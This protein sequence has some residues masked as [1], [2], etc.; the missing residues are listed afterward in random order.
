MTHPNSEY[1]PLCEIRKLRRLQRDISLFQEDT[2][3][4]SKLWLGL[5]QPWRLHTPLYGGFIRAPCGS[6][7]GIFSDSPDSII[8]FRDQFVYSVLHLTVDFDLE[9]RGKGGGVFFCCD[10]KCWFRTRWD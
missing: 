1:G 3:F 4:I 9:H 2:I 6:L 7:F 8:P 5:F 10:T